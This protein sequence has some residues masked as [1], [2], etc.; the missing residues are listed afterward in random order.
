MESRRAILISLICFLISTFLITGYVQVKRREMTKE[1][2]EEVNVIVAAKTIEEYETITPSMV[3]E[4]KV[5]KNFR[6]PQTVNDVK[7]VIG[8]SAYV[9]ITLNEQITLTKL[10]HQDGKPV[11]DRQVEKNMRAVTINIS[12][13]TGVGRLIRPGNRV[14]VIAGPSFEM[15]GQTLFEVKTVLQNRV[16]LA[17]GKSIQNEVPTK[18]NRDILTT[19][20]S[21]LALKKRKDFYGSIDGLATSR[22]D[23]DYAT[24]TLQLNPEEAEKVHYLTHAFGDRSLYLVLRNSA[25]QK[26]EKLATTLLDDILG[27]DSDFGRSKVKPPAPPPPAKPR[28]EDILGGEK[29]VPK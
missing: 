27:P 2:G 18:V 21:E 10:I 17:T 28:F 20:E 29:S 8:K 15:G 7:D 22:L 24:V 5:F 4:V 11:L 1:F 25:D 23:D 3:K 13:H 9:P 16:V 26:E 19:I 6:Q 14:D 12:P